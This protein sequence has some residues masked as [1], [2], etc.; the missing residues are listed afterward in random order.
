MQRADLESHQMERQLLGSHGKSVHFAADVVFNPPSTR[1]KSG[2][3]RQ[4]Y[5]KKK[6]QL[7]SETAADS[8]SKDGHELVQD[9][10]EENSCGDSGKKSGSSWRSGSH[11]HGHMRWWEWQGASYDDWSSSW[12]HT[13]WNSSVPKGDWVWQDFTGQSVWYE[14]GSPCGSSDPWP[15]PVGLQTHCPT[16]ES[17]G[18]ASSSNQGCT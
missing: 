8:S 10:D 17:G 4:R 12:S 11:D 16:S 13:V 15:R 3:C 1:I 7:L 9:E 14:H 18:R 6:M 5:V 2:R